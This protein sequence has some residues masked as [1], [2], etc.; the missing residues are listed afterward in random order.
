MLETERVVGPRAALFIR[1]V[2]EKMTNQE[3]A[4]RLLLRAY[5]ACG[6]SYNFVVMVKVSAWSL[7]GH[8][9]VG[10]QATPNRLVIGFL[11]DTT[12]RILPDLLLKQPVQLA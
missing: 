10:E 8:S 12:R 2:K 7:A 3:K 4:F 6:A 11:K 5:Q 9:V 1:R